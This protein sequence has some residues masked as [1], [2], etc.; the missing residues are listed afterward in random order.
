MRLNTILTADILLLLL[1]FPSPHRLFLRPGRRGRWGGAGRKPRAGCRPRAGE[2]EARH[3]GEGGAVPAHVGR[4][5]VVVVD[6]DP[7]RADAQA[8]SSLLSSGYLRAADLADAVQAGERARLAAAPE[9]RE[10]VRDHVHRDVRRGLARG[11]RQLLG[12]LGEE[13]VRHRGAGHVG[14][15]QEY[16]RDGE[17]R[18]GQGY[19]N[20]PTPD[21]LFSRF[22]KWWYPNM[23]FYNLFFFFLLKLRLTSIHSDTYLVHLLLNLFSLLISF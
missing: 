15:H 5:H 11:L 13:P 3:S 10:L 4:V 7:A 2:S 16:R 21:T 6:V 1:L 8:H 9:S 12:E 19:R 17:G 14:V 22:L 18:R 20:Q 23:L